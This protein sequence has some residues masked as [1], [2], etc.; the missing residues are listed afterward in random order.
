MTRKGTGDYERISDPYRLYCL[1]V[2]HYELDNPM[3]LY[4]AVPLLYALHSSTSPPSFSGIFWFN[5][6]ETWVDL[7]TMND[8]ISS[9]W[10]TEAGILDFFILPG[11]NIKSNIFQQY[12]S[13]TGTTPLPPMWSLG[14]HQSKWNYKDQN[15][16]FEVMTGFEEAHIPMDAIWLDIEHTSGHRY[17]TW[18]KISFPNPKEM[19]DL[20][21]ELGKK[22][23]V[24]V[25]PH[26]KVD[27]D[28]DIYTELSKKNLFVKYRN[29]KPYEGWCWPGQAAF[30]DF[31]KPSAQEHWATLFS[32][33]K[34]K[35]STKDV[36]IW[37]DM[38]EPS[39]FS[40]PEKTMEKDNLHF[41][42]KI[43]HRDI[44]NMYG[45]LMTRA[46]FKGLHERGFEKKNSTFEMINKPLQNSE[47]GQRPFILSRSF[48]AG[49]QRH[50]SV[51]TGDNTAS[52]DH[53]KHS[54]SMT[55]S[56][57]LSGIPFV[58]ADVGGFFDDPDAELLTRWFQVAAFQPFFREHGDF[59]S[60]RKEPFLFDSPWMHAMSSAIK[61]RYSYLPY[62]YSLFEVHSR[63]GI[64]VH[65]PL[66]LE[67][68]SDSRT[69]DVHYQYMLGSDLLIC[70]VVTR[71]EVRVKV[72]FP[73]NDIFWYDDET[74]D[75]FNGN[76]THTIPAPIE[77][78]PTFQ[79]GGS[80]IVRKSKARRNT[81]VMKQDPVTIMIAL[82]TNMEAQGEN[83]EDEGEG[84][85]YHKEDD[86]V[87]SQ[88]I[89]EEN[90]TKIIGKRT[91]GERKGMEVDKIVVF[92]SV[93]GVRKVVVNSHEVAFHRRKDLLVIKGPKVRLGDNWNVAIIT[94]TAEFD[95]GPH[96]QQSTRKNKSTKKKSFG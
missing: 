69:F 74:G 12:S 93:P 57:A 9:H 6:A 46:T 7:A 80:V 37:N 19:I 33:K 67:F 14:Y 91:A 35:E 96:K 81:E 87:R 52:W 85:S 20:T 53:M 88:I 48:F 28:W 39:V 3:A 59:N 84:Y 18:D 54:I 77:K 78:L 71:K 25:D 61:K 95:Q 60:L 15:E 65:R 56:I 4:G 24:I 90:G 70:P 62:I 23:I 43:E 16:V 13:L 75:K 11:P 63:T 79:R 68:P 29:Q 94:T 8:G 83:Y 58:G 30:V 66:W 22:T 73:G 51:W 76:S 36:H 72:Y 49:S 50:T 82:D 92:G 10:I 21:S 42:S 41:D 1:D 5:S 86:Y 34:Y 17:F 47:P 40:G 89:V 64:P 45:F 32:S 27:E 38:N 44:H 55:L 31:V 2:A 26:I